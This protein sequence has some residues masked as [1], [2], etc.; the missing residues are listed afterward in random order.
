M[1][2]SFRSVAHFVAIVVLMFFSEIFSFSAFASTNSGI[3]TPTGVTTLPLGV[4]GVEGMDLVAQPSGAVYVGVGSTTPTVSLDVGGGLRPGSSTAVTACGGGQA[5]GE[6]TQRYNYGTHF[7][8]YC[9][10]TQWVAM[11]TTAPLSIVTSAVGNT[12]NA[13]TAASCP[14]GSTLVAGGGSCPEE[15]GWFNAVTLSYPS[16]NSWV[17]GC[18]SEA[19]AWGRPA[20]G[21]ATAYA[22]CE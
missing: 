3:D 19:N 1:T 16:G 5:N 17:I 7:M 8:E 9:N 2:F 15:G 21:G 14:S 13:S 20:V 18:Q 11:A 22:F 4:Q 6:G 12:V 10:G